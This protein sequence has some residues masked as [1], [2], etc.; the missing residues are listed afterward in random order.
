MR[1]CGRRCVG[2]TLITGGAGFIG[3]NLALLWKRSRPDDEIVALDNLRRPGSELALRRLSDAGV[4]F[5][6]GDVRNAEDFEAVKSAQ[7]VI[8]CAAEP[9]VRAGYGSD[10]AYLV[11]N[12]LLGTVNCLEFCRRH[13][14]RSFRSWCLPAFIFIP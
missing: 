7:L 3:S 4:D 2:C 1:A 5:V 8:D 14:A 12:N 13:S 11:H 10:S 6:H 9:S